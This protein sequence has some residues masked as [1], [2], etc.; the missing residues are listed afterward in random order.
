MLI[1]YISKTSTLL[2]LFVLL[3]SLVRCELT[4]SMFF[5]SYTT[6]RVESNC[7]ICSSSE[8]DLIIIPFFFVVVA[9]PVVAFIG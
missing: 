1:S 2:P 6:F 7:L 5:A 9:E 4:R 3:Y 8:P